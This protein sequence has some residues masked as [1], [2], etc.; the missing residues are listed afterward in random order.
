MSL[1]NYQRIKKV[2]LW[3]YNRGVNSEKVNEVYR[4]IIK[5]KYGTTKQ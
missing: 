5:Q 1:S 4:K 3:N 2:M